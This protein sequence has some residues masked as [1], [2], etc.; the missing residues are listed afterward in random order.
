MQS[1]QRKENSSAAATLKDDFFDELDD[2]TP[3]PTSTPASTSQATKAKAAPSRNVSA[4]QDEDKEETRFKMPENAPLDAADSQYTT[5]RFD[6]LPLTQ[7]TLD[8]LTKEFRYETMS[9]VQAAVLKRLP[10]DSD[11]LVKAKTGTGKTLAFLIAAIENV[12]HRNKSRPPGTPILILSPTRELAM[13]IAREAQRLLRFR[14]WNV[15]TAVGGTNR[16]M[17]VRNIANSNCDILVATPGRLN[18]LLNSEPTVRQELDGL[19]ML[20]YDEADVLLDMGFKNE[21]EEINRNLPRSRQTYLFSATVSQEVQAIARSTLRPDY[22]SIDTVPKGETDTHLRIAQSHVVAP[23][24]QHLAILHD[25][26]TKHQ[27]EDPKA[28]ILVFFNTTKLVGFAGN[29]F[30]NIPGM[31]VMQIHSGL[32][33]M[34]RSKIADRFRSSYSSVLFSSDVSARG[35]DY[36][37]VTLVVQMGSPNNKEQYIHRVGRTGRAGKSGRG[38]IVLSSF[39]QPFLNVMNP[40]PIRK[41]LQ[42]VAYSGPRTDETMEKVRN[43]VRSIPAHVREDVYLAQL[44]SIFQQASLHRA[45]KETTVRA[46]NLFAQGVLGFDEPP[47]IPG[48]LARN[49]GIDRLPGIRIRGL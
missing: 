1:L 2:E 16:S 27:A 26:I 38:I 41:D 4:Q 7:P 23:Y 40:I 3:T 29:V 48:A 6:S 10:T 25:I 33:Q 21:L 11:F 37:G 42:H 8:A 13:Q 19:K 15:V 30:N 31:N 43:A 36:P 9:T 5:D 24:S 20:I 22:I 32:T 18:D 28:K 14:R 35:V 47:E 39:D 34:E 46:L 12:L 45:S 49:L 17:N 44:G